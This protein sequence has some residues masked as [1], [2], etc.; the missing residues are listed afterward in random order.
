MT[1]SR[2][3]KFSDV[4]EQS[5]DRKQDRFF[6]IVATVV[7]LLFLL[8][9]DSI[10]LARVLFGGK[11]I[12]PP[13]LFFRGKR[14]ILP[15]STY[16]TIALTYG[17]TLRCCSRRQF[18]N[19][20]AEQYVSDLLFSSSGLRRTRRVSL[21]PEPRLRVRKHYSLSPNRTFQTLIRKLRSSSRRISQITVNAQHSLLD[22]WAL[23]MYESSSSLS[24]TQPTTNGYHIPEKPRT[25]KEINLEDALRVREKLSSLLRQMRH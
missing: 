19:R 18:S 4:K 10:L 21:H 12:H 20:Y 9:E 5:G 7:L 24:G 2:Y 22:F 8:F 13:I 16:E 15:A 14:G 11:T 25:D 23:N 6:L 17:T 3:G 1:Q